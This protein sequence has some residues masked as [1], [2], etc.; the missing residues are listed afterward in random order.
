MARQGKASFQLLDARQRQIGELVLERSEDK[1]L[2]GKFIPGRAFA[3][4]QHLFREF[5]EAVNCRALRKVDELDATIDALG[6]H[7]QSPDGSQRLAIRD[8]QIWSDG[9]ITCRLLGPALVEV[10]GS[11]VT[12]QT[13]VPKG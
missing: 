5:E 2:F 7:L 3:E 9:G 12:T 13:Q 6:L 10:N 1:L 4:V 11:L 8:V